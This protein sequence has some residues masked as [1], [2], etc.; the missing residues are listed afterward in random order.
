M[1]PLKISQLCDDFI[2]IEWET[3]GIEVCTVFLKM[4]NWGWT[5]I[6]WIHVLWAFCKLIQCF[7]DFMN[8]WHR[9]HRSHTRWHLADNYGRLW[10]PPF[11]VCNQGLVTS[12]YACC[13]TLGGIVAPYLQNYVFGV[14][15]RSQNV[16]N[17]VLDSGDISPAIHKTCSVYAQ[18]VKLG[19]QAIYQWHTDDDGVVTA[20]C[21]SLVGDRWGVS[22][23]PCCRV[24]MIRGP[25]VRTPLGSMPG[26][27]ADLHHWNRPW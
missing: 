14:R 20:V 25:Q 22:W 27:S 8:C 3:I 2:S 11:N 4:E 23:A 6:D 12:C 15:A 7:V 19:P 1:W 5:Y 17:P 18:W 21:G 13:R 16:A 10:A 9:S 24:R 26:R